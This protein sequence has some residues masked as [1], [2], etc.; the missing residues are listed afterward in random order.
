M[1]LLIICEYNEHIN[2]INLPI[3]LY[4]T[5]SWNPASI[6]WTTTYVHIHWKQAVYIENINNITN[7]HIFDT[8][9]IT[10]QLYV[11]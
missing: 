7:F 1:N 11:F 3:A 2:I 6:E 10:I 9:N 4:L 5:C 8:K